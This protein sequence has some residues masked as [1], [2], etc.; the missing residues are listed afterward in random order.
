M[1]VNQQR[2]VIH[3]KRIDRLS[4]HIMYAID[5]RDGDLDMQGDPTVVFRGATERLLAK[6]FAFLVPANG[7]GLAR[8]WSMKHEH[9]VVCR[10]GHGY[11][12]IAVRLEDYNY[13]FCDVSSLVL[14]IDSVIHRLS[15]A[16]VL[17]YT[18]L[19]TFLN[20]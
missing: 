10:N 2:D 8:R 14:L 4:P 7:K 18:D 15:P 6:V 16:C 5:Y 11:R 19:D 3:R 9:D 20:T 12:R 1:S 17:R 13:A